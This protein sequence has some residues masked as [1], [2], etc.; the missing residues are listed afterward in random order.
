MPRH[1]R[2][3]GRSE[4]P[5]EAWQSISPGLEQVAVSRASSDLDCLALFEDDE[6]SIERILR[7]GKNVDSSGGGDEHDADLEE[8]HFERLNDGGPNVDWA[9][10]YDERGETWLERHQHEFHE[11][12]GAGNLS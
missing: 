10:C 8:R 5:L 6:L 9:K 1:D 11:A 12:L 7:I 2:L 3:E 4:A